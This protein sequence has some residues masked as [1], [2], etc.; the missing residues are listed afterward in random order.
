M[1][2]ILLLSSILFFAAKLIHEDS[3][4]VDFTSMLGLVLA[5]A[6]ISFMITAGLSAFEVEP[7]FYVSSTLVATI[8]VFFF[9]NSIF[10]WG[11]EKSGMLAGIYIISSL[12]IEVVFYM[13]SH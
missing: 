8:V 6:I 10:E 7:I 1:L 11:Y 2:T 12:V 13:I 3:E 4:L 5:P 9:S